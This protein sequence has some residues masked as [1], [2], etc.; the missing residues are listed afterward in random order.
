MDSS[1]NVLD[2]TIICGVIMGYL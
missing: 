1:Y 2:M